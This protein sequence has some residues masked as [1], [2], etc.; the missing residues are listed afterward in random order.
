MASNKPSL[1]YL[2]D[3]IP[4][5]TFLN[6]HWERRPLWV[7][8]RDPGYFQHLFSV[9]AL[10]DILRFSRVKPPE[11]KVVREQQELLPER[12]L[13]PTGE[14]HL[15]QIYKVFTEGYTVIING[16]Q[17]FNASLALFCCNLQA[18]LCHR[19][20]ANLY[21]SPQGSKALFPHYDTHDV[22]VLQV[23]G[24]KQW[25]LYPPPQPV[26]LLNSFQP[27][28]PSERLG[29]PLKEVY[30]QAGDLLYI[31]RGFVHEAETQTQPSLH[32]TLGVYPFQW[33]DLL[34][35]ALTA[36]SLQEES[37]RKALPPGFFRLPPDQLEEHFR[38]LC[39]R[40][41]LQTDVEAGLSLLMDQ[42]IRQAI[43]QPDHHFAL[44]P[45]L[46]QVQIDTWVAK[47][48]GMPCRI[49]SQ[50]F[51]V[52]IQFPGNT[53]KGQAHLEPAFQYIAAAISPFQVSDLPESLSDEA[54]ITLVQ[55]LIRGGLLRVH[56]D[57]SV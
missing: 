56:A 5:E 13:K 6:D 30:L 3:P 29:S 21:F 16:L 14:I 27:V 57:S 26:P 10:E 50:G 39:Q 45:H 23:E 35:S 48:V 15:N 38:E 31:P 9:G 24:S 37:L 1:D 49:L 8:G 4:L 33:L 34:T 41:A 36:L 12:Y 51:S 17:Q 40:L 18:F 44:I 54:K 25:Y 20:V 28:I 22:F 11:I 7:S 32:L 47:R 55:R 42:F 52:S 2:L 19:I 46:D 53:I 43:V